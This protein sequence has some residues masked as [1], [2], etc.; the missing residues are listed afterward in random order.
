M[1]GGANL[2]VVARPGARAVPAT[3]NPGRVLATP[4]G[5]GRNIAENLARLGTATALVTAVGASD[6]DHILGTCAEA[7][8]DLT[9]VR[10]VDGGSSHYV[11]MLDHDGELVGAVADMSAIAALGPEDLPAEVIAGARLLVIEGNLRA[12]TA[13]RACALA[14]AGG[15]PV[16]IDPVSA[17]KAQVLTGIL[18]KHPVHC[19]SAGAEELA[20]FGAAED[21]LDV[22]EVVWERNGPAGSTL[23]TR[24]GRHRLA[25]LPTDVVDVTGAGDSMLAA[26]CHATLAGGDP[27]E[28]G[29]YAHAAA[30][31]T[32]AS[33]D[34]VRPDLSDPLVRSLL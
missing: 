3:S 7:G 22:V 17:P 9:H 14:A 33:G 8:V 11:A 26:W 24:A 34:T 20:V 10:R 12:D 2:D 16:V 29:R 32:V 21:L 4:G 28:A 23:H 6:G 13:D 27:V 18:G 15:I 19:L 25:S 31:L 1:V 5:V 30:A